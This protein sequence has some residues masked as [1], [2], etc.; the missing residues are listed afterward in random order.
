MPYSVGA[1]LSLTALLAS[2]YAQNDTFIKFHLKSHYLIDHLKR[3][4]DENR[5]RIS[6]LARHTRFVRRATFFALSSVQFC[7]VKKIHFL[8]KFIITY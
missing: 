8:M 7:S 3:K 4:D 1:I 5:F 2:H 6:H